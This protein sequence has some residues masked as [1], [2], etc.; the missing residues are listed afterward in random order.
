MIV[1]NTVNK[2]NLFIN[3]IIIITYIFLENPECP[4]SDDCLE[5]FTPTELSTSEDIKTWLTQISSRD[6]S[7]FNDLQDTH[8]EDNSVTSFNELLHSEV[9]EILGDV[10]DIGKLHGDVEIFYENGDY[11]WADFIHGVKTGPASL[12][13]HNGDHFQGDY[14]DDYLHGLVIETIDYCDLHNVRR[15]VYYRVFFLKYS[16]SE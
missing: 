14:K 16:F 2:T 13:F 3:L 12:V 15:E 11:L 5:E 10:D 7:L 1:L 8:T 4:Y 9:K 6:S